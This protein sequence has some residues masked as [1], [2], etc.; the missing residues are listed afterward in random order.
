MR[1]F[2]SGDGEFVSLPQVLPEWVAR[3]ADLDLLAARSDA[4][5]EPAGGFEWQGLI[6]GGCTGSSLGRLHI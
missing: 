4:Y 3:M 6:R 5:R 2:F 1:N